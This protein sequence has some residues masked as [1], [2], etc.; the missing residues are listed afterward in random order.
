MAMKSSSRIG[1][2]GGGTLPSS[3]ESNI[4]PSGLREEGE[5]P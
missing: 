4:V 5:S 3:C 2:G 1:G